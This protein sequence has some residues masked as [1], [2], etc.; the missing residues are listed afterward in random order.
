MS[1]ALRLAH[2]FNPEIKKYGEDEFKK[3]IIFISNFSDTQIQASIKSMIPIRISLRS[4]SIESTI[5]TASCTCSVFA[6]NQLCK[7]VWATILATEKKH[8][9]F[10]DS[11]TNIEL[12]LKVI[13]AKE[14]KQKMQQTEYKKTQYEKQKQWAKDN[15]AKKEKTLN[16]AVREKYSDEIEAALAFFAVNGFEVDKDTDEEFLNKAKKTLSRVF[17]PDKGGS[18]DEAIVLNQHFEVLIDFIRRP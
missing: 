16:Q 15:K 7:H 9:D 1:A 11:K 6:K 18:H 4:E 10:L 3:N 5:F 2:L 12:L 17:H 8:P 14:S 13:S